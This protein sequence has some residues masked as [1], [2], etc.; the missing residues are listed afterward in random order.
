M[1]VTGLKV[2]GAVRDR[3][4]HVTNT[5]SPPGKGGER[6]NDVV[7]GMVIMRVSVL[8]AEE[9]GEDGKGSISNT[10]GE[11]THNAG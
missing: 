9:V 11:M 10:R 3:E 4:S 1:R 2:T 7:E 8:G 5:H 6:H